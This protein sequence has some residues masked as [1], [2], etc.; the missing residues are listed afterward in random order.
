MSV[1]GPESIL[2]LVVSVPHF[3]QSLA[4]WNQKQGVKVL[5][6]DV[7]EDLVVIMLLQLPTFFSYT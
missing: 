3:V 4:S 5:S 2:P 1:P 6:G 7:V